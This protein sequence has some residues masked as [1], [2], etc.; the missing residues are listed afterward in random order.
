MK[1]KKLLPHELPDHHDSLLEGLPKMAEEKGS[2]DMTPAPLIARL[3]SDILLMKK[4]TTTARDTSIV[5]MI[6]VWKNGKALVTVLK[7]S[8]GETLNFTA[9]SLGQF[10]SQMGKDAEAAAVGLIYDARGV[11]MPTQ[12]FKDQP[13]S[14]PGQKWDAWAALLRIREDDRLWSC[15]QTYSHALTS[16]AVIWGVRLI[17]DSATDPVPAHREAFQL[18]AWYPVPKAEGQK[19]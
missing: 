6:Y 10:A 2:I 7:P 5:P 12:S 18:P 1:K 8:P 14:L 3:K 4:H 17:W 13:V 19:I 15:A 16:D 9:E 11:D